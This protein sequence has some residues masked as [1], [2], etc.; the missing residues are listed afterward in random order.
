MSHCSQSNGLILELPI[1]ELLFPFDLQLLAVSEMCKSK[2]YHSLQV[3]R[4]AVNRTALFLNYQLMNSCFHL[5]CS[6]SQSARCA[7][8]S[9]IIHCRYVALQSIE[10]PYS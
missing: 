4:T 10:R 5:T 1:D 2:R 3:C 9:V 7:S 8:R 6:C